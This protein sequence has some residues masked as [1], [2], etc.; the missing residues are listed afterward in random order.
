[1]CPLPQTILSCDV[2]Q[3]LGARIGFQMAIIL[4][5]I[6]SQDNFKYEFHE[7][8]VKSS[9]A[10]RYATHFL[11]VEAHDPRLLAA[12]SAPPWLKSYRRRAIKDTIYLSQS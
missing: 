5:T 12:K 11:F 6:M 9:G 2:N 1:M 7:D 8:G 3:W 10:I 4:R